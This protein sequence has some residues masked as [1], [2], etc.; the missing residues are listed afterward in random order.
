MLVLDCTGKQLPLRGR[1]PALSNTS[2][3]S[4]EHFFLFSGELHLLSHAHPS[5]CLQRFLLCFRCGR[6]WIHAVD[7]QRRSPQL[8]LLWWDTARS[9]NNRRDA[10]WRGDAPQSLPQPRPAG[11]GTRLRPRPP[12][13]AQGAQRPH[14]WH[15]EQGWAAA[16][17]LQSG[18]AGELPLA[19]VSQSCGRKLS[20]YSNR[21]SVQCF[22][23]YSHMRVCCNTGMLC[24]KYCKRVC[25]VICSWSWT[26]GRLWR[27]T[28]VSINIYFIYVY[29][30][31]Y[32]PVP[33][34][35]TDC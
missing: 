4:T 9:N 23:Q 3:A 33:W 10:L 13:R 26:L 32:C 29:A 12:L 30:Y 14:L 34:Q 21:W 18:T 17:E 2:C 1:V 24:P 11:P 6:N 8:Q 35:P 31:I 7:V 28:R 19:F 16:E 25:K 27:S 22:E 15:Q 5:L 20:S